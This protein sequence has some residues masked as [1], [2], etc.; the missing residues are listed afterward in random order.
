MSWR[1]WLQ[2]QPSVRDVRNHGRWIFLTSSGWDCTDGVKM[3]IMH[4]NKVIIVV[5]ENIHPMWTPI[6]NTQSNI[7]YVLMT[8]IPM[9]VHFVY[10]HHL[11]LHIT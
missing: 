4:V 10:L 2:S 11:V 5:V 6:V 9:C 1:V 7:M 3:L 8:M